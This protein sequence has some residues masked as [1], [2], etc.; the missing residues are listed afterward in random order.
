MDAVGV[1][2]LPGALELVRP[3]GCLVRIPTL[4]DDGDVTASLAESER[5]GINQVFSTMD[6]EGCST[7]LEKIA[8]LIVSGDIALPTLQSFSIHEVAGVHRDLEQGHTRG[9]IVLD[10]GTDTQGE[11]E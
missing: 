11:T 1:S 5:R 9:K 8:D 3:G 4:T 6:S 2:T 10:L 7:A